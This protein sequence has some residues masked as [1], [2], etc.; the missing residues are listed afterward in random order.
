MKKSIYRKPSVDGIPVENEGVMAASVDDFRGGRKYDIGHDLPRG[1]LPAGGASPLLKLTRQLLPLLALGLTVAA[2]GGEETPGG[3]TPDPGTKMVTLTVRASSGGSETRTTYTDGYTPDNPANDG[4]GVTWKNDTEYIGAVYYTDMTPTGGSEYEGE[5]MAYA[6]SGTG[7]GTKSMDFTGT[8]PAST[9]ALADKYSYY[10][11]SGE[12]ETWNISKVYNLS[13]NATQTGNGNTEHLAASDVMYTPQ[14]VVGTVSRTNTFTFEHAAALLRFDLTLPEAATITN[15]AIYASGNA[16]P[17]FR[18]VTLTFNSDATG[19]ITPSGTTPTG[20]FVLNI[21]GA[22]ESN[23]LKAYLM[24]P[25]VT[26]FANTSLTLVA[27]A[28]DG[29]RYQADIP[30]DGGGGYEFEGGKTYTFVRNFTA[31]SPAPVFAGSNIYWDGTRLTFDDENTHTHGKYQGVFFKWGSLVGISP[32]GSSSTTRTVYQPTYNTGSPQESTWTTTTMSYSTITSYFS[33]LTKPIE[34]HFVNYFEAL[35]NKTALYAASKGDI[36]RYLSTETG[37]VA[38]N[39]RM[40]TGEELNALGNLNTLW[41][42]TDSFESITDVNADGTTPMPAILY[43]GT[44]HF[45]ASGQNNY[46][47]GS[48]S[49]MGTSGKYWTAEPYTDSST[50]VRA[51]YFRSTTWNLSRTFSAGISASVRCV[52]VSD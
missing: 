48:I 17:F 2:C 37:Q 49:T 10:Y 25:P 7:T 15:V 34:N 46:N 27:Y 35:D 31:S 41:T 24:V 12:F 5:F 43:N 13:S 11:P 21:S 32:A 29:K 23:T 47:D 16:A 18:D 14:A 38:G 30:T 51:Q 4:M 44:T 52:K 40:P 6:F 33:D 50:A 26:D 1:A 8:I 36:C 45:P 19:T 22:A 9:G 42:K 20:M 3:E 39:W 28:A